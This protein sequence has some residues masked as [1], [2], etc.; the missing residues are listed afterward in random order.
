MSNSEDFLK[1]VSA[2]TYKEQVNICGGA[3]ASK[4]VAFGLV[5][6]IILVFNGACTYDE[7]LP[8]GQGRAI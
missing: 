8:P 6:D 5:A 2:Y 4:H 3:C 7:I 1:V